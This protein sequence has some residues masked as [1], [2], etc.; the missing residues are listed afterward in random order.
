VDAQVAEGL[1]Q[2]SVFGSVL[3]ASEFF[4]RGALGY[5]VTRDKDRFDGLEL[6]SLRW[7]VEPLAV[8]RVESS[9]FADRD[10]FP[11][12]TVQFDSALVMRGIEHEWHARGTLRRSAWAAVSEAG[13]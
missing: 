13:K 10:R 9:F 2:A 4:E 6:K 1:P 11:P 5:S 8:S 3:E 12:G 7:Q